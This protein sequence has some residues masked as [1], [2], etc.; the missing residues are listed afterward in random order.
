MTIQLNHTLSLLYGLQAERGIALLP[1]SHPQ[2]YNLTDFDTQTNATHQ[3]LVEAQKNSPDFWA[4]LPQ[5]FFEAYA[6]R[7]DATFRSSLTPEALMEWY[8]VHLEYPI[9]QMALS[10]LSDNPRF[11]PAQTSA[12]IHFIAALCYLSQLRDIGINI[13]A[14]A[15]LSTIDNSRL[16][17]AAL[18]YLARERLYLGLADETLKTLFDAARTNNPSMP[19]GKMEEIIRK[20]R[21]GYAKGLLATTPLPEWIESINEEFGSLRDALFQVI[22]HLYAQGEELAIQSSGPLAL[23]SDVEQNLAFIS[24]LPLFRGLSESSLR[25]LL[26]NARL[27]EADKNEILVAQGEPVTRLFVVLDGWVKAVKMTTEGQEAVLQIAGKKEALLDI[28]FSAP[29]ISGQTLRTI[30]P[31]RILSLSLPIVKDHLTRNRE[32]ILNLFG[33][34]TQRLQRLAGQFEQVTLKSATQRVGWFLVNLHLETGLE[35]T[36]LKLPFDK[37]LIATYLNIKPETLSRAFKEFRSHGF[38]IDK[39]KVILPDPHALCSFCDPDLAVRC[40]RA[41]A[42]RCA[43]IKMRE[44]S[45][46]KEKRGASGD[47]PLRF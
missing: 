25:T 44:Q 41:E 23:A 33:A 17:N 36:P 34:T 30:T 32:L 38:V 16:K 24:S 21:S 22:E 11:T 46:E 15:E 6:Q 43:P 29:S 18:S 39:D 10:Q 37:A 9:H 14:K 31:S 7:N 19:I 4:L 13:Y 5:P 20:I 2:L 45:I 40:C 8:K 27:I 1:P 3:A 42:T 35:G 12:L 28:S 47:A 26:K